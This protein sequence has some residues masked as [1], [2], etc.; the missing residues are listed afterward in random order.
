ME[1]ATEAGRALRWSLRVGLLSA[2]WV[3]CST[4][5]SSS[6]GVDL[7]LKRGP[8]GRS[9]GHGLAIVQTD[10]VSTNVALFDLDG[11]LKSASFIHSGSSQ[12]ELNAALSGDVVFPSAGG[13]NEL[14][15]IDR[16]PAS[17]ISFVDTRSAK[18]RGQL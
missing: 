13:D 15:L 1:S 6:G 7:E 8:D 14:V 3:G 10:Y 2:W 12:G 16:Y 18:V 4:Q 9:C 5:P 17:V 11:D